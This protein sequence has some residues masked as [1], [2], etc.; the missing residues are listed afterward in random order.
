MN[1]GWALIAG[2][3]VTLAA[4]SESTGDASTREALTV[5]LGSAASSGAE[6]SLATVVPGDWSRVLFLCPYGREEDVNNRLGFT[7]DD[8]PGPDDSEGLV[9]FV[10]ATDSA[11]MTWATEPCWR[12]F[13]AARE[14]KAAMAASKS[15]KR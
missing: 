4:C 3:A 5:A 6:V 14:V 7:W 15:S 9:T 11:V 1:L 2:A 12:S 10:F 8:Y 13:S